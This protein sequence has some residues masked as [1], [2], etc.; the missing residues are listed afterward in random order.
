MALP[1]VLSEIKSLQA[2]TF[3]SQKFPTFDIAP[4]IGL[5]NLRRL[6]LRLAPNLPNLPYDF[7][8]LAQVEELDIGGFG[9]EMIPPAVTN[10]TNLKW[11]SL[12]QCY[13]LAN[14]DGFGRWEK[15][16]YLDISYTSAKAIPNTIGQYSKLKTLLATNSGLTELPL[17]ICQCKALGRL[18]LKGS[19]SLTL[20]SGLK[21]DD[22]HDKTDS[23]QIATLLKQYKLAAL[24]QG[25][26]KLFVHSGQNLM[27]A[28]SNGKSDPYCVVEFAGQKHKTHKI[29]KTLNPVWDVAFP[30]PKGTEPLDVTFLVYDHDAVGSDDFLG[31][32]QLQIEVADLPQRHILSLVPREGKKDKITSGTI[33]VSV[34]I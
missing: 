7:D 12:S 24:N 34:T 15:L 13:K 30:L 4:L 17:S 32:A 6:S 10:M 8:R 28:D 23:K 14:L 5:P 22:F 20:L 31:T 33:T 16:E 1:A 27:A 11:L 29:N 9:F 2:L 18:E 21:A 25:A 19:A 26:L 3:S